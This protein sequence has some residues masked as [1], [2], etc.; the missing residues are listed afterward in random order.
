[1]ENRSLIPPAIFLMLGLIVLGV[2]ISNGLKSVSKSSREIKVSGSARKSI[3]S[4]YAIIGIRLEEEDQL[5]AN[6]YRKINQNTFELIS[7]LRSKGIKE[8]EISKGT[9]NVRNDGNRMVYENGREI[10]KRPMFQSSQFIEIKTTDFGLLNKIYAEIGTLYEKNISF[11][12][13]APRYYTI[14]LSNDK[15][16]IQKLAV[17]DAKKRA[18]TILQSMDVEIKGI[19]TISMGVIQIVPKGSTEVSDYGMN[20]VSSELKDIVAVTHVTFIIED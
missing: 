17:Q 3:K 10:G 8:N 12:I 18:E 7:F 19:K 14:E 6:A 11:S 20:D 9:V 13:E 1:M 2:T 16:E 15:A 5:S 4:E